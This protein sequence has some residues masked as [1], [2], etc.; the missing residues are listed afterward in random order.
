M[1][2]LQPSSLPFPLRHTH[3]VDS[4]LDSSLQIAPLHSLRAGWAELLGR[5]NGRK[6]GPK[7]EGRPRGSWTMLDVKQATEWNIKL[8][9]FSGRSGGEATLRPQRGNGPVPELQRVRTFQPR[10]CMELL[11]PH[12][13]MSHCSSRHAF[14][15]VRGQGVMDRKPLEATAWYNARWGGVT[16]GFV[17][18]V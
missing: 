4:D 11:L 17:I 9:S 13:P 1:S 8:R 12:W 15:G 5:E 7:E 16:R 10:V 6:Q 2:S 3:P 18:R 14:P